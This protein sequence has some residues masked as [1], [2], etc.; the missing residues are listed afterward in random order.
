MENKL[1]EE[2]F[3]TI[4]GKCISDVSAEDATD[5]LYS[6]TADVAVKFHDWMEREL[7][8][9][10]LFIENVNFTYFIENIYGK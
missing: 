8:H 6:L 3:K 9:G 5:K 7:I 2:I 10:C 4:S 1:Q